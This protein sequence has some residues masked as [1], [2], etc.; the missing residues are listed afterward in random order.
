[1]TQLI[2]RMECEKIFILNNLSLPNDICNTIKD[3]IF[4]DRKTSEQIHFVRMKKRKIILYFEENIMFYHSITC[5]V[6]GNFQMIMY[7]N[8]DAPII[9]N[10]P[11]NMVCHCEIDSVWLLH[12]ILY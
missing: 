12:H 5:Y 3:Y 2:S 9:N 10:I 1:M 8:E 6:C 11:L 7:K 4:Y